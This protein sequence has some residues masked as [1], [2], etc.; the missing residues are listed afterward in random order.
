VL[1]HVYMGGYVMRMADRMSHLLSEISGQDGG[2]SIS[3]RGLGWRRCTRQNLAFVP[4]SF[5]SKTDEVRAR[6]QQ[7]WPHSF[8]LTTLI[9]NH[10]ST[11]PK[12]TT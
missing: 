3:R 4:R 11:H 7:C 10:T 5:G 6:L 2:K 1:D 8:T 9:D 12:L